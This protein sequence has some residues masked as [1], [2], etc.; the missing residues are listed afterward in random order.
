M[1]NPHTSRSEHETRALA[2]SFAE[3]LRRGDVVALYGELGSGKT[4][5]V[6]GVCEAFG[7][8]RHVASPTFI[9]QNRYDGSAPDGTPMMLYH[10]D[11]YRIERVE[12]IYDLGYEEFLFGDG[13]CMIEWA[14]RLGPLLPANRFDVSFSFGEE[15]QTRLITIETVGSGRRAGEQRS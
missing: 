14:E 13:I 11:L 7:I 12:E 3:T 9:I 10:F 2:R 8:G 6:K 5:F 4:Q 15:D 1:K